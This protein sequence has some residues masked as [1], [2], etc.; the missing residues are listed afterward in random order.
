MVKIWPC[1]YQHVNEKDRV[2]LCCQCPTA[3]GLRDKQLA[4]TEKFM[5][6]ASCM[7]TSF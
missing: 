2:R 5:Q 6:C 4:I 1:M 7:A 3:A